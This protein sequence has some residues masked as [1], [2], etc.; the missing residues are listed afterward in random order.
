VAVAPR[1]RY[2]VDGFCVSPPLVPAST[3]GRVL[4]AA[5]AV[6]RGEYDTGRPP[7]VTNAGAGV[8]VP[9]LVKVDQP[10]LASTAIAAVIREPAV[11]AW[12]AEVTGARRL[13]VF[14]VQLLHKAPG[15]AGGHVGWHQDDLYWDGQIDGEAFTVWLALTDVG[16][17]SGPMQLVRGSHRWGR[18]GGGGF[19]AAHIDAQRASLA[20]PAGARWEVVPA[21]L[22]AGSASLHHRMTLH[23]S[24]DNTG[25]QPRCSLAIHMRTERSL[26]VPGSAFARVV[27]DPV[28]APVVYGA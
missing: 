21:V 3:V 17:S 13:Q 7:H 1:H 4:A 26:P 10:H 27:E 2:D 22:P 11:A 24:G 12:A 8:P 25:G 20:L 18:V 5:Q 23:G 15:Q 14:A 6:I 9:P 28:E 16:E 19:V